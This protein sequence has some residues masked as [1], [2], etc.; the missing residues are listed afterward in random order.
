M[1]GAI[2]RNVYALL[3][4]IK[5]HVLERP[6]AALI[7]DQALNSLY[8]TL[9]EERW[10]P[11]PKPPPPPPPPKED[12]VPP[13]PRIDP[14][15]EILQPFAT[16]LKEAVGAPYQ[17]H[18]KDLIDLADEIGPKHK[19]YPLEPEYADRRQMLRWFRKH[20]DL[21]SPSLSTY[22]KYREKQK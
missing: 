3:D 9:G 20:F 21:F 18:M 22:P 19:K 12:F 10:T 14:D 13:P 6:Q 1:D 7:V 2:S 11:A 15:S 4:E 8:Q 5:F 16:K 17:L